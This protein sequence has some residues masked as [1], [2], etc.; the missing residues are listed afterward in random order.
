MFF[1]VPL[2]AIGQEVKVVAVTDGDTVKVL[3]HNKKQIKVRL[4]EI[5]TPER[6]QPYGKKAKQALSNMVFGKVVDCSWK[7]ACSI[8]LKFKQDAIYY[9]SDSILY[10]SY[11]D[12]RQGLVEVGDFPTK[13]RLESVNAFQ[14]I[15]NK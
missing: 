9:V 2:L 6:K 11:C 5:D 15:K 8:G 4:A 14:A 3:T 1:V 12:V 10:V 13:C 7:E